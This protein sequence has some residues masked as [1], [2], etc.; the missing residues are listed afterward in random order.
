MQSM[1]AK[2]A[3]IPITINADDWDRPGLEVKSG[4]R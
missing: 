1:D 3:K 4:G 2:A